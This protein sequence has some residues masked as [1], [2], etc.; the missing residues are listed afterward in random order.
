MRPLLIVSIRFE[1]FSSV[2]FP[3]HD[4]AGADHGLADRARPQAD[5]GHGR[6]STDAPV[7]RREGVHKRCESPPG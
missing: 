5:G 7:L 3:H 4:P 2:D 1:H 6:M